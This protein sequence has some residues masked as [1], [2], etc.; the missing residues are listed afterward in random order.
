MNKR[1]CIVS[2]TARSIYNFRSNLMREIHDKLYKVTA[3]APYDEYAEKIKEEFEFIKIRK[4]DRSGTNPIKDIILFFE[5]IK[6]YRKLKPDFVI[7]FTIK[8]NIYSALACLF[9]NIKYMCSVTGLGHIFLKESLASLIVKILFKLS[10]YFSKTVVCQKQDDKNLL[11]SKKIVTDTKVIL[12][13]GSGVD[14]KHFNNNGDSHK[15]KGNDFI[16]IMVSRLL[17]EKGVKEYVDASKIIKKE[18][19]R[20]GCFLLGPVDI[21]NP[22][23][24]SESEIQIWH[25]N[26]FIEYLGE[27]QN[28]K[29]YLE[30]ADAVVLPSYYREGIPRILLEALA[31]GKPVITTDS[32]GC[33]E[34]VENGKNGFAIP[35]KNVKALVNAMEK[36]IEL[37]S[38]EYDKMCS[39]SRKKAC[40]EFDER[41]VIDKYLNVIEKVL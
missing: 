9:L 21:D 1:I 13:P 6:I 39:Y 37:N 25:N 31:M 29:K 5:F 15:N 38:E 40:D 34:V 2:N 23:C 4:L 7:N 36:M 32:V 12:T 27:T 16:F 17:K 14:L 11:V 26:G 3:L 30:L 18:K 19:S 41:I 33:R 10:F 28:V 35:V 22:S 24:I 8:P 20:V